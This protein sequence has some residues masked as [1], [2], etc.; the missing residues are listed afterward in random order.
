MINRRTFTALMAGTLAASGKS[1][2]ETAR[3]KTVFYASVGTELFLYD[4]DA[5]AA[6]LTRRSSVMLPAGVQYAWPHPSKRFFYV[7][8]SNGQPGGGAVNQ[9]DKH[10]ASAFRVDPATG[11]LTPHGQTLALTAR[12]IHI[13]IDGGG[14]FAMI[15]YNDPSNLTVYRINADGT[16]GALVQQ[17]AKPDIGIYSHQIRTTPSNKTAILV[18]RGN[19]PA[20]GKGEDPGSLK[21]FGFNEGQ[22]TNLASYAPGNGYGFGPRHLDFHPTLP[23][24]YVSL[25]RQ[26]KLYTYGLQ[27]DGTLSRDPLFMKDSLGEPNNRRAGQGAGTIHVH[28]NGRFVYQ[29]NRNSAVVDFQGK[30]VFAGGE[31]NMAVWS[32]DQK[33]G[34]PTLIQT[35]DG[36]ANQLRTFGIDPSGRMLVAASISP[37]LMRE[38]NNVAN[39]SAGLT[40]YRIGGD[41]KLSFVRK[42]D[43]DTSKGTQFWSGMVSLG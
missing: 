31:N 29:A 39:L 36:H 37:I 5:E 12:P 4:V 7:A 42:Y 26:N 16:L 1:F 8:S 32:I 14:G 21:V 15:A 18:C 41:G 19:N 13:S 17:R 11:A 30:K 3:G 40:V 9:G 10:Y 20:D 27:L 24:V 33:T 2:A 6:A 38:G 35:A 28:P 23:F 22:L 43:V 25:E 34:E